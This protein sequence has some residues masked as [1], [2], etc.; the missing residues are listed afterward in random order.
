MTDERSPHIPVMPAEICE[1]LGPVVEGACYVDCTIGYG[2]HSAAISERFTPESQLIG[3]DR[4]EEALAFCQKRFENASFSV[5][6]YRAGFED[7]EEVLDTDGIKTAKSFLFDLGFSSPQIDSAGRGFSFM[8]R[9]PLDMR[10]DRRQLLTAR[11]V[12]HTWGESELADIFKRY[13]EERF[14]RRIAKQIVRRRHE[15]EI[16]T[17]QDLA[18]IVLHAIPEKYQHQEGIHPATRVFQA[19]RIVVNDELES[20]RKGLQG[21]LNRLE[22]GGRIAVLSYHSLEHRIVKQEMRNFCGVKSGPPGVPQLAIESEMKG[23]LL[24]RKAI[25]PCAAEKDANQRSRSAQLRVMERI[26]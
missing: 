10:M 3:L 23:T 18:D 19:L 14:S 4:D 12:V 9:G 2:G 17:T 13:G 5:R 26:R 15:H 16:E 21:A 6:F 22:V 11:E 20:L 8:R 1:Y 7:I 24:T 25:T